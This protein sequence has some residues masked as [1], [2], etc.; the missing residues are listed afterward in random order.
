MTWVNH[1]LGHAS[2][3][4]DIPISSGTLHKSRDHLW[5]RQVSQE[6]FIHPHTRFI[7][8]ISHDVL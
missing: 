3:P 5:W 6:L 7:Y 4:E 1:F 8:P 2:S